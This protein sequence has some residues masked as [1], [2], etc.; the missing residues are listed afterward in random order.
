[1]ASILRFTVDCTKID[2]LLS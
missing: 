2:F 1:M